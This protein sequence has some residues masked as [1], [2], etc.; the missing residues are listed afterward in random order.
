MAPAAAAWWSARQA[1]TAG[2]PCGAD[3]APPRQAASGHSL[4]WGAAPLSTP[5]CLY[6]QK[7]DGTHDTLLSVCASEPAAEALR[8]TQMMDGGVLSFFGQRPV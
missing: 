2:H 4:L 3:G 7:T 1:R 6:E 8:K 5:C